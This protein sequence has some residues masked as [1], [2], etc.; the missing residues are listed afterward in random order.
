VW[1]L[2]KELS[3]PWWTRSSVC[4]GW[5]T[6]G[7]GWYQSCPRTAFASRAR[8]AEAAADAAASFERSEPPGRAKN[9]VAAAT[10]TRAKIAQ[11]L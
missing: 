9:H 2:G 7:R 1:S 6:K 3:A 8:P 10:A 11:A 5:S 4:F